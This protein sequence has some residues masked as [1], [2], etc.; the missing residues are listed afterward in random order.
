M[1]EY[2]RLLA[3]NHSPYEIKLYMKR[4]L[5]ALICGMQVMCVRFLENSIGI[6]NDV[7]VE[8][9]RISYIAVDWFTIIQFPGSIVANLIAALLIFQGTVGLRRSSISVSVIILFSSSA[10]L[11]ASIFP[12]VYPMVYVGQFLLGVA[13]S[14]VTI[15]NV[16]MANYWF[17][18]NEVGKALTVLSLSGASASILAFLIP[19]NVLKQLPGPDYNR[20]LSHI[21][22]LTKNDWFCDNQKIFITYYGIIIAIAFIL[23]CLVI[24][25]VED[26]P[27]KPPSKVQAHFGTTEPMSIISNSTTKNSTMWSFV[28]ETKQI[29]T[30]TVF[31]LI[32]MLGIVRN[33]CI[34]VYIIFLSEMLRPINLQTVSKVAPN[35][36]SGYMMV[37]YNALLVLGSFVASYLLDRFKKHKLQLSLSVFLM[38]IV[39]LGTLCGVYYE[40]VIVIWIFTGLKGFVAIL[41]TAALR[42]IAVQHM[43]PVKPGLVSAFQTLVTFAGAV[44]IA[45]SSRF[46]L[47]YGGGIG[48]FT[49]LSILLFVA[50]VI[51][52]FIKP[53]LKRT[54]NNS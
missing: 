13:Y 51:C 21:K 38:L 15:M 50:C 49:Y 25:I 7:Y 34:D 53:D 11:I 28:Q 4:W 14:T 24:K 52:C 16:Q 45:Q 37:T 3:E 44:V 35:V 18:E 22:N 39:I 19:S 42:D 29:F 27:P 8:Y 30:N 6:V 1:S 54:Q 48:V 17:P 9:F 33:G 36:L 47:N 23:L 41:G 46:V 43:L 5:I 32:S 31:I 12:I 40:N 20:N 10:M 26:K 2:Q